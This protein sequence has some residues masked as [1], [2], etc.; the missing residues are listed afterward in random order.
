MDYL[1]YPAGT[2]NVDYAAQA[3]R[4]S[5]VYNPSRVAEGWD[6]NDLET[7]PNINVAAPAPTC[8]DIEN[9]APGWDVGPFNYL[10]GGIALLNA[11]RHQGSPVIL[12][13]DGHVAADATRTINASDLP[14]APG[15]W[16][17]WAGLKC[18]TWSDWDPRWGT[19]QHIVPN[20]SYYP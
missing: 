14:A 17:S 7:T 4:P 15:S 12:Y 3:I 6:S 13:A 1:V 11:Y 19:L 2:G 16:G 10:T 8:W 18:T 9:L 5:E 20:L